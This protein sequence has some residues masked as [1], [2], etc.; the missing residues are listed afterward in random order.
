MIFKNKSKIEPSGTCLAFYTF[1]FDRSL[2][3]NLFNFLVEYFRTRVNI[4]FSFGGFLN[5][6]YLD[7]Y[8]PIESIKSKAKTEN[9]SLMVNFQLDDEDF[10]TSKRRITVEYSFTRPE[11][12]TIEYSNEFTGL[13]VLDF[14]AELARIFEVSYGFCYESKFNEWTSAYAKANWL[15][16]KGTH[17]I[18]RVSRNFFEHWQFNCEKIQDGYHRDIYKGNFLGPRHLGKFISGKT[19]EILIKNERLGILKSINEKLFYWELDGDQ[20]SRAR[21][22]IYK[23]DLLV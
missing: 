17:Q 1:G 8:G 2:T 14:T 16:S 9:W 20:L 12:V 19:L 10:R 22:L 18:E 6:R 4:F 23:S 7:S 5:E 13:N 21:K 15:R 3:E 11:M